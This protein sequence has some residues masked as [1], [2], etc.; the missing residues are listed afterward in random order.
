MDLV[1]RHTLASRDELVALKTE[2]QDKYRAIIDPTQTAE[3]AGLAGS[4]SSTL[5]TYVPDA[6]VVLTWGQGANIEIP[7]PKAE[8]RVREDGHLSPVENTGHGMQR[9]FIL[10]LLQHLACTIGTHE[11]EPGAPDNATVPASPNLLLLI[12]EPELYQHPSR[13]RHFATTLLQLAS[14]TIPGVATQTQVLYCTHSPL[15]VGL[16]R[17]DQVRL[18]RKAVVALD[19][20]KA[21]TVASAC[22]SDIATQLWEANG[23]QGDPYHEKTLRPRLAAIT[24]PWVNEGFF[25]DLVV[26]VEGESDRSAILTVAKQL[27]RDFEADGIAVIPCVGKSNLDRPAIIFRALGIPIYL[28]WDGDKGKKDPKPKANRTLLRILGDHEVD[29]PSTVTTAYATFE[30]DLESTLREEL[31]VETYTRITGDVGEQLGISREKGRKN[32]FAVRELIERAYAEGV[33][34]PT[35]EAIVTRIAAAKAGSA[36]SIPAEMTPENLVAA[37]ECS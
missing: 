36:V 28:V 37:V 25:A 27:G 12:E 17:F 32:P 31:G 14:G 24:T 3:V 1:I 20:P 11:P 23:S 22:L 21:C 10:T 34:A 2:I 30:M 15:F 8:V 35:L 5:Q 26:L 6:R 16:D 19:K 4:L 7:M 29:F 18:V 33:R 9:A 13:Q